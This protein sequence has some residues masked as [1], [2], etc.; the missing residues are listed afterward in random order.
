MT[1]A[2]E[3]RGGGNDPLDSIYAELLEA[4]PARR[5]EIVVRLAG[6]HPSGLLELPSRDGS[7][8]ILDGID[9]RTAGA[10]GVASYR[11]ADLRG[12]KL[13]QAILRGVDFRAAKLGEAALG[14]ADLRRASLE[15]ADLRDADL[16]SADL[17]KAALGGANLRGALLED[18]NLRGASLR[19][20]DLRDAAFENADLRGADL[21]G[22]NLEGTSLAGADLR[23]VVFREANLKGADLS[24]VKLRG[25]DLSR[26]DCRGAKFD[27]ADLRGAEVTG[28]VLKGASLR[29]AKLQ[30]LDLSRC[31]IANVHL[32]GAWLQRTRIAQEQFGGAIGEELAGDFDEARK[33]YLALERAFIELG[34]PDAASWAYRRKRRMQKN[35]ARR[36][37]EEAWK[38]RDWNRAIADAF[39]YSSDQFV[40][41]V[42]D[43]G[44]S[45]A[46]ILGAMAAVFLAF[47]LFYGLTGGVVRV[48]KVPK[49]DLRETTRDVSDLVMF[50]LMALT[51]GGPPAGL[52][53]RN[54]LIHLL[55]GVQALLGIA[56]TGLLGFVAGNL[57]RR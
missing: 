12:A 21:W 39:D 29:G 54:E 31:D 35:E 16:A 43:Y 7:G 52:E 51:S 48:T 27:H 1:V 8:A 32:G 53:P 6:G 34:D 47:T 3:T 22:A 26:A 41:W 11:G 57:V 50:S 24:A 44:E 25:S 2:D 20:A 40:E 38:A 30:G 49:G 37:S 28:V 18:A 4:S 9:L 14:G 55:T 36:R 19:F 23:G 46:R 56:L 13:R 5:A 33:G 42:C 10:D 17:R 15:E 45:I